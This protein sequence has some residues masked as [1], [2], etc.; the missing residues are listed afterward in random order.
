MK[1]VLAEQKVL[2]ARA[3]LR[4]VSRAFAISAITVCAAVGWATWALIQQSSQDAIAVRQKGLSQLATAAEGALNRSLLGADL[5]LTQTAELIDL[6]GTDERPARR[7]QITTVLR[8]QV[9]QNLL[10]REI[11]LIEPDGTMIATSDSNADRLGIEVPASFLT[12]FND[13]AVVGARLSSPVASTRRA[14]RVLFFGRPIVMAG[15]GRAVAVAE[16]S[17]ARLTASTIRDIAVDGIEISLERRDGELLASHP[18]RRETG[19]T[20]HSAPLHAGVAT[21]GDAQTVP[22]RITGEDVYAISHPAIYADLIVTSAIP[23]AGVLAS[24]RTAQRNIYL[25]AAILLVLVVANA[26]YWWRQM[27]RNR[28]ARDELAQSKATVDRALESMSDGFLLLDREN[29]AITWNRRFVEIHPWL[30]PFLEAG[31]TLQRQEGVAVPAWPTTHHRVA[32]ADWIESLVDSANRAEIEQEASYPGGLYV[33]IS[34]RPTPDGGAVLV[35]RDVTERRLQDN[36][37]RA[38]KSDLEATLNAMPDA[39]YELDDNGVF[40]GC[41]LPAGSPL[42]FA[43]PELIG[44][45]FRA[46]LPPPAVTIVDAALDEARAGGVSFGHQLELPT[47]SGTR[48]YELSVARKE[49]AHA[50]PTY[51]V[52]SRDITQSRAAAAQ[53][54]KLALFDPLTDLP[55]RRMLLE[56]L[57]ESLHQAKQTGRSVALMFI[58]LDNFK[59]LND[60]MRHDVGDKLLVSVARR[61]RDATRPGDT[62]GRLG[63]DEFV[64]VLAQMAADA[65]RA[66]LDALARADTV[67]QLLRQPYDLGDYQHRTTAS[68]GVAV[69]ERDE[70]S[71]QEVLKR[72]DIAMYAAKAAG[73]NAVRAYSPEMDATLQSRLV[74]ERDLR[75]A[76]SSGQFVLHYQRQVNGIGET[77]GAE[78]LLRW[79]HPTR[80][81][82]SPGEFIAIA[83]DVG[84]MPEIGRWVMHSACEQMA[85]WQR[86][87]QG[88]HLPLAINVSASQL[89]HADFK[90]D[91]QTAIREHNIPPRELVLEVTEHVFLK[92]DESTIRTMVD[93]AK[94]GVRFSI[95]DFGTGHASLA[96]L[97]RLPLSQLKIAQPFVERIGEGEPHT[98]IVQAIIAMAT[99][100]NLELIAEGVE[101]EE[102][103]AFLRAHGCAQVQGFLSGRPVPACDFFD[104]ARVD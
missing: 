20:A 96:Y 43:T 22:S 102:Q 55:N 75:V 56:R 24:V 27:V 36:A 87:H 16:I 5:L 68:I 54:E 93:I 15:V 12:T 58:D 69:A 28:L 98:S 66:K 48:W 17:I 38:S 79:N 71:V 65:E 77:I 7:K 26:F 39:L 80:G 81:L 49:I 94:T 35:F 30:Q 3:A 84:L 31:A 89:A 78:A 32:T 90:E 62:V 21:N 41:H 8:S 82:I 103:L 64:V 13:P 74:L 104:Q 100:L 11:S 37:L 40:V 44:R 33:R 52:I 42:P 6:L 34:G 9:T 91:L 61:L 45:H 53:I 101:R 95:D 92:D 10:V 1:A 46:V 14:E 60:T 83:E 47:S 4:S 51:I 73:R 76:A 57:H 19:A 2:D 86:E 23:R 25:G 88:I 67:L 18:P 59:T 50:A 63:G 72:A 85:K 97:T 99:S 70:A 29:R